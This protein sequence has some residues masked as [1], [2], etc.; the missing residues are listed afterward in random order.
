MSLP[1]SIKVIPFPNIP[2]AYIVISGHL[3]PDKGSKPNGID[4]K[5]SFFYGTETGGAEWEPNYGPITKIIPCESSYES[6]YEEAQKHW[7]YPYI[8]GYGNWSQLAVDKENLA[9]YFAE[10]NYSAIFNVLK[11]YAN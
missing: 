8:T 6:D 10:G 9:N 2:D 3:S 1:K 11:E 7:F 4:A 5:M